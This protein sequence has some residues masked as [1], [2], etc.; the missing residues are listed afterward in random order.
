MLLCVPTNILFRMEG[1]I[2]PLVELL[3]F[4]DTKVQKAAAGAL[5]TVAFKNDANKKEVLD[6]A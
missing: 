5:R 3:E 1:G 6:F 4:N 2:P